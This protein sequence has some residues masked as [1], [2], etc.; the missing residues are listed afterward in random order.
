MGPPACVQ[1]TQP[2]DRKG[3]AWAQD[4]GAAEAST[5]G[6]DA[7]PVLVNWRPLGLAQSILPAA[8]AAGLTLSHV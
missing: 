5:A 3:P 4:A 2:A 7:D 8:L 6:A 1:C